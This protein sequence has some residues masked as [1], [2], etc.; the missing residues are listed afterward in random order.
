MVFF[1]FK[2]EE[3]IVV[4]IMIIFIYVLIKSACLLIE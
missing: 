2:L 4:K 1:L 3:N